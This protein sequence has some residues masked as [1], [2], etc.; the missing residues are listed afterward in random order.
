[1][2]LLPCLGPPQLGLHRAIQKRFLFVV[3]S[4]FAPGWQTSCLGCSA[5]QLLGGG[6]KTLLQ[7]VQPNSRW[8]HQVAT[9]FPSG[10]LP[11][12]GPE[13]SP[14]SGL[15]CCLCHRIFKEMKLRK[16]SKIKCTQQIFRAMYSSLDSKSMFKG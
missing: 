10:A 5:Q 2:Y 3:P 14:L 16:N 11:S 7:V 9:A 12:P 4:A 8:R 15:S 6:G 1:M 13:A